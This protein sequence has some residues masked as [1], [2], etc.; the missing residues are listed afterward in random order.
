M[1]GFFYFIRFSLGILI[2]FLWLIIGVI[3]KEFLFISI[4][5]LFGDI[6]RWVRGGF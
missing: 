2:V 6:Y 4:V 3:S 1:R 5:L